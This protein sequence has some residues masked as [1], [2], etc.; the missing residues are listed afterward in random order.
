MKKN[1]F[2]LAAL[3]AIALTSCTNDEFIGEN[4]PNKTQE[5]TDEGAIMFGGGF[6]A[7]TRADKTDK[8]AADLLNSNFIVSGV[9]GTGE[10]YTDAGDK[11][12][13]TTNQS[14][15][16]PSFKVVWQQNTAGTTETNTSDWEYVGVTPVTGVTGTTV[17]SIKY[18]DYS[19]DAYNFAAYSLGTGSA[20]GTSIDIDDYTAAETGAYT[21]SGAAADL[22]KCYISDMV[23]VL[24]A[25]YNKEVVL[26]FRSLASKVRMALYE[27]VP[28]YS[29]KEVEFFTDDT[30]PRGT[31][32]SSS[33]SAVL[34]GTDAFITDATYTV[35][36][37]TIGITTTSDP[38]H[39]QAHVSTTSPTTKATETFGTLNYTSA[40]GSEAPLRHPAWYLHRTGLL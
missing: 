4:G 12:G 34:F 23:T 33:T 3:G 5:T 38:D 2:F 18:W 11:A 32:I 28:G 14:S 19:T 26:N 22:S 29:I 9:K 37:P 10:W 13:T 27:T 7:V 17:Q 36:F 16:F 20:T 30:T 15:V 25:N 6:K 39:N 35:S 31:N 40:E 24:N 1:L 21:L 8:D